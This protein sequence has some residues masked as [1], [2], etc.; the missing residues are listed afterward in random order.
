MG[1]FEDF[2][3]KELSEEQKKIAKISI[4][5]FVAVLSGAITVLSFTN[6]YIF[7]RSEAN[8]LIFQFNEHKTAEDKNQ[9]QILRRLDKL[10]ERIVSGGDGNSKE[11]LS[12]IQTIDNNINRRIDLL[13]EKLLERKR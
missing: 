10:E 11:L 6:S 5:F 13:Y 2:L 7:P 9:E 4:P 3:N 8:S 1:F 12:R